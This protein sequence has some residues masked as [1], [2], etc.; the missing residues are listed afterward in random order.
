VGGALCAARRGADAEASRGR[1][2]E[3]QKGMQR[4]RRDRGSRRSG[5]EYSSEGIGRPA[6]GGAA[7][8][9]V[10]KEARPQSLFGAA[11]LFMPRP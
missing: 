10:G 11:L 4:R 9:E 1:R 8:D 3:S 7:D 6:R 2:R 5:S